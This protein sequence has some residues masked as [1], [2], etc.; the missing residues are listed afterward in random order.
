MKKIYVSYEVGVEI[1]VS[2][3]AY[4]EIID[5]GG[6][7]DEYA[8]DLK[9]EAGAGTVLNH[10]IVWVVDPETDEVIYG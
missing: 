3:E 10:E 4:E 1:E 9:I 8:P 7:L 2:D 6:K 5:D